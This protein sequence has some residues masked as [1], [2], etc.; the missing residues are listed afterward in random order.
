VLVQISEGMLA[1]LGCVSSMNHPQQSVHQ[2][3]PICIQHGNDSAATTPHNQGSEPAAPAPM[4]S[5]GPSASLASSCS[6]GSLEQ[7]DSRVGCHLQQLEST[8]QEQLALIDSDGSM[9]AG[10][11]FISTK[12]LQLMFTPAQVDRVSLAAHARPSCPHVDANSDTV[13]LFLCLLHGIFDVV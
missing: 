7:D 4:G 6:F 3:Q 9:R 11:S 2:Q 12:L 13:Q 8:I 1:I 5:P 10:Q